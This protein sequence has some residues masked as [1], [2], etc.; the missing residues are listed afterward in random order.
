MNGEKENFPIRTTDDV[1]T[2]LMIDNEDF[3]YDLVEEIALRAERSL[4]N[5]ESNPY[6]GKANIVENL[7]YFFNEQ[8]KTNS[9]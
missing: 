2:D 5:I 4:E 1:F 9:T 3:D 7:V 8:P 6:Y